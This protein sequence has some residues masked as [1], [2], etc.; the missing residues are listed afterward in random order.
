MI[1]ISLQW[2][3]LL[4]VLLWFWKLATSVQIEK[5]ITPIWSLFNSSCTL[6]ISTMLSKMHAFFEFIMMTASLS[7]RLTFT[8]RRKEWKKDHEEI[9]FSFWWV[10]W[11][12]SKRKFLL[13]TCYSKMFP[14][15]QSIS[16]SGKLN[17]FICIQSSYLYFEIF[18]G[19]VWD[20]WL[21]KGT[22]AFPAYRRDNNI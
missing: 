16:W 18:S 4:G 3:F 17:K 13:W 1:E 11:L 15:Y 6:G 21:I 5:S 8:C 7:R 19:G 10:Y 22:L 14:L 2:V 9:G 12:L 20:N